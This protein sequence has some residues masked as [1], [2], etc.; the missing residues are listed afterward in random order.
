M[1]LHKGKAKDAEYRQ[2]R[3]L[4]YGKSGVGK[5]TSLATLPQDKTVVIG[6]ERGLLPLRHTD[7]AAW[8]VDSY[9]DLRD[10]YHA[11]TELDEK[12]SVVVVDSLSE[13]GE[14][15]KSHIVKERRP[16]KLKQLDRKLT[17]VYEET[18][19]TQDW[20]LYDRLI[21]Q[22]LSAWV[23]LPKHV[24]FTA[25]E[26]WT[27]DKATSILVRTPALNGRQAQHCAVFFDLV[28]YMRSEDTETETA[29]VWQTYS[30]L[31]TIAKDAS[32]S[33]DKVEEADWTAVFKKI[34]TPKTGGKP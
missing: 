1:T 25:G 19:E 5:T 22:L 27:E 21:Q 33:L 4:C 26:V 11:A 9:A 16:Q 30:D 23:Q 24:V 32:G 17:G 28:L 3:A 8:G 18:L 15:C 34:L 7:L 14:L 2:I 20:G 13:I 6:V 29:R 12:T 10:A 31:T